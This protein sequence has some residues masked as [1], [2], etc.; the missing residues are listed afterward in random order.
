VEIVR[1]SPME[2]QLVSSF[3]L[4]ERTDP[5]NGKAPIQSEVRRVAAKV[6]DRRWSS[7]NNEVVTPVD[8]RL[9][10]IGPV[11]KS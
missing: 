9:V 11:F 2:Q 3:V 8:L 7:P 6:V 5:M 4:Q 10:V 1:E